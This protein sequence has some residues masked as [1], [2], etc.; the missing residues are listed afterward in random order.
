MIGG[1]R[2]L[3]LGSNQWSVVPQPDAAFSWL[4]FEIETDGRGNFRPKAFDLKS[5][6]GLGTG[7]DIYLDVTNGNNANDGTTW[8]KAVQDMWQA[9]AL[10]PANG[11]IHMAEGIYW[12]TNGHGGYQGNLPAGAMIGYGDVEVNACYWM[13]PANW[14]LDGNHYEISQT[15]QI[16]HIW[17][18]TQTNAYGA[19][20]ELT[21]VVDEATCDATP[22]S[23]YYDAVAD[24]LHVRTADDRP[25]D[26]DLRATGGTRH[27][28]TVSHATQK[29]VYA[30]N[31]KFMFSSGNHIRFYQ[32]T[33][34]DIRAF[35]KGCTISHSGDDSGLVN[36]DGV[37]LSIF[38]EC[39]LEH[40]V[41]RGDG[42]DYE[43]FTGIDC[44]GIEIDCTIRH[45][46]GQS[47]DQCSTYHDA[48]S[49]VRIG[50]DYSNAQGQIIAEDDVG[51]S[52]W[53]LGCYLH[54]GDAGYGYW[55]ENAWLHGV[56]IGSM[57][58]YEINSV[59]T[60]RV[61][62]MIDSGNYNGTVVAY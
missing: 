55:G 20:V 46:R 35:F 30:E 22:G 13:N 56:R 33:G 14:S 44:H 53:L 41:N 2:A 32:T 34:A 40:G 38:Q 51:G 23:F 11:T 4:P 6:S 12:F 45:I 60:I 26:H 8:A 25:P 39:I 43:S 61:R 54:D 18:V 19:Y 15:N 10:L 42:F 24:V 47:N 31:I 21:S 37:T 16:D 52:A 58:N 49:V 1:K 5:Y 27:V 36:L 62:D 59:G 3:H 48:G 7:G 50:G 29:Y 17:D 28:G 57:A 9:L